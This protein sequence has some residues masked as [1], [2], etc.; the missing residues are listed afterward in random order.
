MIRTKYIKMIQEAISQ[1][2]FPEGVNKCLIT[3]I[4]KVVIREKLGN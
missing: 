4:F 1:G 2:E 3:L